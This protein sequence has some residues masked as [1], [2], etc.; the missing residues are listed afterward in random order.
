MVTVNVS[1]FW[2]ERVEK[3]S[4]FAAIRRNREEELK[5][6]D[7]R[8]KRLVHHPVMRDHHGYLEPIRSPYRPESHRSQ[9]NSSHSHHSHHSHPHSRHGESHHHAPTH[10]SRPSSK[11]LYGNG[12]QTASLKGSPH[13]R[14]DLL[15]L[16]EQLEKVRLERVTVE[17]ELINL[18]SN[19]SLTSRSHDSTMS[20]AD[21]EV[22]SGFSGRHRQHRK[23]Q[24]RS[25]RAFQHPTLGFICMMVRDREGKCVIKGGSGI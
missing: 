5:M 2:K 6:E 16:Q 23:I 24:E 7:E 12:N 18:K 22:R 9:L 8:L 1:E 13:R 10:A 17:N 14:D 4:L 3:E 25:T 15:K 20:K 19:L 21:A 11:S